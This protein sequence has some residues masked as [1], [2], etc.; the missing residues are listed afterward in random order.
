MKTTRGSV[1]S[2][3]V[4]RRRFLAGAAT[5]LAAPYVIP[6]SVFAAPPSNRFGI[7]VIGVGGRGGDHLRTCLGRADCQVL[8]V[9]D[10]QQG[11]RDGCQKTVEAHYASKN[12]GTYKGCGSY[13]DFRELLAHPGID[14]IFIASPENWHALHLIGSVKAGKDV[15]SEK[16]MTLTHGEGVAV[17]E[18]V[19]RYGRVVQIGMQ[20]RSWGIFRHACELVRNQYIG[21]LHTIY[22][23]VPGG[24]ALPNAAPKPVPPGLDYDMWLGPAPYT[25]Y[26]DLK[27][28]FNW[29]F[30][31][32]YCVGWI[33]SWGIHYLDV[34]QWGAPSLCT[35]GL[36]VEGVATFPTEGLANDSYRWKVNIDTADGIHTVY[37]DDSQGSHGVKFIGDK[38]WVFVHRG[39][40]WSEPASLVKVKIKPDEEHLYEAY[41]HHQC[42]F[43]AVRARKDPSAPVEVGHSGNCLAIVS[44]AATRLQRKVQWDWTTQRFIKDDEA[45]RMLTRPMRAPWA[46]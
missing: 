46:I 22:V 3:A 27:C 35:K 4:S 30:M 34:A 19:R 6:S 12:G 41:D 1:A 21:R 15:Y 38:G 17:C 44:D 28:S 24:Q 36:Q 5:A 42:F 11:K 14:C 39:G 25:P 26:N 10:P 33:Q 32:D 29:Y 16:A 40:I 45:N 20:Q 31:S 37:T 7:G 9:C 13:S 23:A 8:A 2:A 18:A 43:D